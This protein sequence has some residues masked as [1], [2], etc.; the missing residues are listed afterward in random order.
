MKIYEDAVSY[1]R[2]NPERFFRMGSPD[3]I[4]LATHVLGDAL[5]SGAKETCT[6][7]LGDWWIVGGDVDWLT[8]HKQYTIHELFGR[9]VALPE[10]GPNSMRAEI[11]LTAFTEAVIT[12]AGDDC[13]TIKGDVP[14]DA[15]IWHLMKSLTPLKRLV[16]FQLNSHD[17]L[18]LKHTGGRVKEGSKEQRLK[19]R[20]QTFL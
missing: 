12:V 13:L 2:K 4:E 9:I 17:A 14:K 3:A 11:L 16:A 1:V 7:R 19:S 6:L 15:E 20:N 10:A 8:N 5:I 18:P